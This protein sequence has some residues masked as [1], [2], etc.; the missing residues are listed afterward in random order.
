MIANGATWTRRIEGWFGTYDLFGAR[1]L[2]CQY[3][4]IW[5]Y[6]ALYCIICSSTDLRML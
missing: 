6:F 2:L 3:F 1:F 4:V 5:M